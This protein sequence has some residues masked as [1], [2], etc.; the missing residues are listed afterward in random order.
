MTVFFIGKVSVVFL[1]DLGLKFVDKV[2]SSYK[3]W[4]GCEY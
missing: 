2:R 3:P 1:T 4:L